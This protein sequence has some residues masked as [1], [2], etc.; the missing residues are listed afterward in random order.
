MKYNFK[1]H[2]KSIFKTI[3]FYELAFGCLFFVLYFLFYYSIDTQ[4][5]YKLILKYPELLNLLSIIPLFYIVVFWMLFKKNKRFENIGNQSVLSEIVSPKSDIKT[6]F[7]LIFLRNALFFIILAMAQPIFGSRKASS[8]EKKIEIVLAL[9]ISNSMNVKDL[10]EEKSR[11]EIIKRAMIQLLNSLNGEKI[12]ICV[13]AGGAYVQLPITLDYG[14]A[15]MFINEIETSMISN[16]GTNIKAALS[17]SF[18]MFSQEKTNKA[19]LLVT[20]GE[21]H[22]AQPS[23]MLEVMKESNVLLAILGIGSKNGGPVPNNPKKPELGN[24]VDANGQLIISKLNPKLI[25][26]LAKQSNGIYEISDSPFPDLNNL[27]LKLKQTSNYT[28]SIVEIEIKRNWYQLFV[29]LAMASLFMLVLFPFKKNNKTMI[30][31]TL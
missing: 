28:N 22:E 4:S 14:A 9:D 12:G 7:K 3:L 15:K 10:D 2:L 11:I 18:S 20:D 6:A 24:K 21:N 23:E 25:Q 31:S 13:F 16:Q 30:N 5:T 17:T 29:F 1:Y 19:I 8:A 26:D 27:I